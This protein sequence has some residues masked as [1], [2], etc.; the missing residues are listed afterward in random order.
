MSKTRR[1][2]I[3]RELNRSHKLGETSAQAFGNLSWIGLSKGV[4]SDEIYA[5]IDQY[6]WPEA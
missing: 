2:K 5:M 6:E 4:D 3:R 1:Q